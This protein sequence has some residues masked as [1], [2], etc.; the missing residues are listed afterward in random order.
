MK[1]R[2]ELLWRFAIVDWFVPH[3]HTPSEVSR[4]VRALASRRGK[5]EWV[6]EAGCW[7]G[8][9]TAKFSLACAL[10]GYRLAIYDSFQGVEP[11]GTEG[12]VYDFSD[13][14]QAT[15]ELVRGHVSRYGIIKVCEFHPGWFA[16]TLRPEKAPRPIRLVY[17]DCDLAKGT[18]EVLDGVAG[19]LTN[20][21]LIFSQDYHIPAV[22]RLLDDRSIRRSLGIDSTDPV[23]V[24]GHTAIM[25]L[26]G[27]STTLNRSRD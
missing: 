15:E 6:I 26:S 8:G 19:N 17:I 3:A 18:R 9:S 1:R 14:Y 10:L 11:I 13:Q 24:A 25:A 7:R 2:L 22:R 27:A 5:G 21:A 23:V 20:D 12:G 16:H 4:I